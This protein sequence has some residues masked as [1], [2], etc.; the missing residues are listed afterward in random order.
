MFLYPP[1][2]TPP[3]QSQFR[4]I[5]TAIPAPETSA[6]LAATTELFP[7]VNCYQPPILWD[8]ADGFQVFDSAGNCWIDFSST[9][10]MTNAGHGHPAIRRALADHVEQGLLAQFSY[11]S[12][13]RVDLARRLLD[14]APKHC[15]KVY[16]WTT[17][18]ETSEC[19]LRLIR[20][21][22]A[23]Q[24]PH[25]DQILTHTGDYHGWTLG[26]QFVSGDSARKP[27]LSVADETI[28]HLPTPLPERRQGSADGTHG[29]EFFDKS[30][31]TLAASG[32][33]L[34]R[35]A[36]VFIEAV[37]GARACPWP[38]AYVQRLREWADQHGVLL[39]FDEIQTG[40]GRTGTWFAHE[41]YQVQAD[42]I[43]VGKGLTSS[44][45]LAAI[46]GSADVLDL[47]GPAAI[48]TTHAG[49]PL[50]CAAALANLETL[51]SENLI[52]ESARKGHLVTQYLQQLFR[53]I[54]VH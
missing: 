26:A 51:E 23:R 54:D 14:I 8:R 53:T 6:H 45:P 36:G 52:E 25:K 3:V 5:Q 41:H 27:W 29:A 43:C 33:D 34:Q 39:I 24:T 9:A 32:V 21:W 40:F 19:A 11:A 12:Q 35:V 42:L 10:I 16:F 38:I 7:L 1:E 37:P 13:I 28:H 47:L 31:A 44:L 2:N 50:S 30:L 48:A 22:G 46:L 20:E 18:S 4:R 49:H 17:G 15:N